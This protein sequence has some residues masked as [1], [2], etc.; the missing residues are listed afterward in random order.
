MSYYTVSQVGKFVTD[1]FNAEVMLHNILVFGEVSGFKISQNH[2]YFTLKDDKAQLQCSCF[3]YK[4]TYVPKDGETV[5]IKCSPSYYAKGG[6]LSFI[7]DFI[8][9]QG[10][11]DLYLRIEKLK[12]QL[13]IEGLFDES[14]KKPIP[15]FPQNVGL[16]T[17]KTGAVI[18][19]IVRTIRR[20][21]KNLNLLLVDTKVQGIGAVEELVEGIELLDNL[22][23]DAIIIARGGG[24]IEDL[25]PFNDEKLCRKIASSNTPI[26]SAVGHETDYTICDMVSDVRCLTPTAAGELVG[27]EEQNVVNYI[28]DLMKKMLSNIEDKYT[29]NCDD[30][31]DLLAEVKSAINS[32]FSKSNDVL[33]TKLNCIINL[34]NKK[35]LQK[36]NNYVVLNEKI[37]D[38]GN[39]INANT[40]VKIYKDGVRQIDLSKIEVGEN[41]I[42]QSNNT[43]L[44]ADVTSKKVD[45]EK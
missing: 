4:K 38:I 45:Y 20:K 17:S 26:I 18:Q 33:D 25:M 34:I 9:P 1:I 11:G 19:D 41:I 21:N 2:A 35:V 24:S 12:K 8:E 16:I 6:R 7:V 32:K 5:I 36:Q 3:N 23:L 44:S 31:V 40:L 29:D 27:Y 43:M 39:F 37:K 22:G 13:F 42:I 30:I 28:D 10:K 15:K 14:R